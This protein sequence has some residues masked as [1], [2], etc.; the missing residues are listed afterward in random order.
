MIVVQLYLKCLATAIQDAESLVLNGASVHTATRRVAVHLKASRP[1][2]TVK[3][4]TDTFCRHTLPQTS[5]ARTA[6]RPQERP[7][8]TPSLMR[9][10]WSVKDVGHRVSPAAFA[11]RGFNQR[12]APVNGL[13]RIGQ[14]H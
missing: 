12:G 2:K 10:P 8:D 5:L 6:A 13:E 11:K 7:G 4:E 3:R 1:R 14:S 9:I